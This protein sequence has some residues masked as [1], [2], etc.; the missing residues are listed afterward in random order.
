MG[1]QVTHMAAAVQAGLTTH[2]APQLLWAAV[3]VAG[4]QYHF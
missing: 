3:G 4:L 2:L 1:K